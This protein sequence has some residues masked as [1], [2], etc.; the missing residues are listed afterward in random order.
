MCV[1]RISRL[2]K[3]Y[4]K[5]MEIMGTDRSPI[6]YLWEISLFT[7][8]WGAKRS[9]YSETFL[10]KPMHPK[11]EIQIVLEALPGEGSCSYFYQKE[12]KGR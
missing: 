1:M 3:N 9:R 5:A 4:I 2:T 12:R 10:V 6:L 11:E 7:D 8:V